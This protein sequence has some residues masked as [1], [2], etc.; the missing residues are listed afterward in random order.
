VLR[1][2]RW[3]S[4][5][6][7]DHTFVV[8]HLGLAVRRA[9]AQRFLTVAT[10]CALAFSVGVLAAGPI[11]AAGAEQAIVYAYMRSANPLTKDTFVSLLT[12]PGFDLPN[13]SQLV[14][15]GL[16]PLHI[17]QLT[18]QEES[19]NSILSLG[20][21]SAQAPIAYR[22]GLFRKLPLV[23]GQDPSKP[24][25]VLVPQPL[26]AAL[27]LVPGSHISLSHNATT[28]ATVSGVYWSARGKDPLVYADHRLLSDPSHAPLLTTRAG[29]AAFT[30]S[31]GQTS[32]IAIE[33]DAEP[34]FSGLTVAD[35]RT[36]A[37]REEQSSARI[38]ATLGGTTV[39]SDLSSLVPGAERAVTAGLAPIYVIAGEVALV[40]LGVLLGIGLL[41]LERQ[42]FE[43]AVLTTRGARTG[44]LA[45]IQAAEA[46]I[47]AIAALPVSLLAAL[48]LAVVA[49]AAHGPA[50]PGT[51][52]PIGLNAP[53]V[54]VALGGMILGTL[55]LVVVSL[56][57]LRHTVIQE[58]Q[59]LSRTNRSIWARLPYELVPL[60]LGAAALTELHRHHLGGPGTGLDLLS[61]GAPTLLLLGVAALTARLLLAGARKLDRVT[62]KVRRPSSYLALRRLSRSDST[63]WLTLLLVL[64]AALFAFATS[65]RTT[66]L[67]RNQTAARAQVG[68]DWN[69]SVAWPAQGVASANRLGSRATLA[70]YGSAAA[71]SAPALQLATIIGVDPASYTGAGWWQAR[72][73]SLPLPSLLSRLSAPPIGMALSKG[74]QTLQ[75]RVSASGGTGLRLWAVL[76]SPNNI[77]FQRPLGVLRPGTATYRARLEGASRL[78]SIV[79]SGS[80]QAVAPLFRHPRVRLAFEHLVLSGAGAMRTVSLSDWRGLQAGGATIGVMPLGA[81]GLQAAL[82]VSRGG[83]LG[84]IAPASAAVPVLIGGVGR[85]SASREVTLQVGS[86]VLPVRAVGT[87]NAFPVATERGLPFAVV[88]VRALIERFEQALQPPG[89][90]V[91]V[92]L[93]M[94]GQSPVALTRRAGLQVTA[95]SNAAAIEAQ[96]ASHQENLAIG[97]EFAAAIAGVA[98]A[99]LA[100]VLS[101]YFGGRRHEYEAASFEALGAKL[102]NVVSALAFE[103]GAVVLCSA[104]VGIG[105]G[106]GLLAVTHS[107]VTAPAGGPAAT[108]LLVD[109]PA[110]AAASVIAAASLAGTLLVAAMRIRRLSL[111][112]I[113]RGEPE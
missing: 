1:T 25:E 59:R 51:P 2:R 88:P 107:Y 40:G 36:L 46:A 73:A 103:Y 21:R 87:M 108:G 66:E 91:F 30:R 15:S 4:I 113:L 112:A 56:P 109:W 55:A 79:V 58:R 35:L 50:L 75:L 24:D 13:A 18:L 101:A 77:F 32:D 22:D 49:R 43:L 44:E 28:H 96:L 60:L 5:S 102:R 64:S 94:A 45:A 105:L 37:P 97:M 81:G 98:L 69:L 70:F 23:E 8:G 16:A 27:G 72:D 20:H 65:L 74:A 52:F 29:F 31:F 90:G 26:A 68:A 67:T 54:K 61:L 62:D 19:G 9:V 63:A 6:P 53:A 42:S 47:A 38:R 33:W 85:G 12:W 92:V 99:M 11:Y 7:S 82:S 84:A 110:I 14:R 39:S 48:G 34:S 83:P 3:R 71:S 93:S 41:K 80:P 95:V 89:G 111:V 76:S 17:S 10:V 86:L 100:L 78:L 106:F 57:R 104:A